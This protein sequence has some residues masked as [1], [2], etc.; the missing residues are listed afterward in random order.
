MNFV[1]WSQGVAVGSPRLATKRANGDDLALENSW[2]VRAKTF[3]R[4]DIDDRDRQQP[5]RLAI[6]VE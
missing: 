2:L 1:P 3:P 4:D 6:V 5:E